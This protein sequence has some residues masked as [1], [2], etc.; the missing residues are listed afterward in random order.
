MYLNYS[1]ISWALD[2]II[3]V[4]V[5]VDELYVCIEHNIAVVIF[6]HTSLIR[7]KYVSYPVVVSVKVGT[8]HSTDDGIAFSLRTVSVYSSIAFVR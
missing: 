6:R 8:T 4:F 2:C 7:V 1:M 3:V 5:L